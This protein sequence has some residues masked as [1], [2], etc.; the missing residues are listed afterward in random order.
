MNSENL[1]WVKYVIF[2]RAQNIIYN[3]CI[4]FNDQLIVFK[5]TLGQFLGKTFS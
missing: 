3:A 1:H 5:L 4:V 2:Y